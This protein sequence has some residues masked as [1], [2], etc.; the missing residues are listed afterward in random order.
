MDIPIALSCAL[1]LSRFGFVAVLLALALSTFAV[2]QFLLPYL[3]G[4]DRTQTSKNLPGETTE[5]DCP[6]IPT[7]FFLRRR[8]WTADTYKYTSAYTVVFFP[9]I[10]PIV[11]ISL[12]M[13]FGSNSLPYY[14]TCIATCG[15]ANFFNQGHV[16]FATVEKTT[17]HQK[18]KNWTMEEKIQKIFDPKSGYLV[19]R[20]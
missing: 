13:L 3:Y 17:I 16:D 19:L 8:N 10:S 14:L 12:W 9:I 2:P 7:L 18:M 11:S 6:E 4:L 20:E 15:M 1:A 5:P